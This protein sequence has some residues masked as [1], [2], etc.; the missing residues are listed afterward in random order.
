MPLTTA[1]PAAFVVVGAIFWK[2]SAC[3]ALPCESASPCP[4]FQA[5]YECGPKPLGCNVSVPAFATAGASALTAM[6][7][8][9]ARIPLL[10]KR[11]PSRSVLRTLGVFHHWP[12]ARHHERARRQAAGA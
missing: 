3:R 8:A 10:I 2:Y 12:A 5:A 9:A 7:A 4:A 1:M 11:P 6:A